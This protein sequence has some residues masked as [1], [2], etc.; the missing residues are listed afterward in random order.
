M[1]L[2]TWEDAQR[3]GCPD[4]SSHVQCNVFIAQGR[5]QG[6]GSSLL[7]TEGKD[8]HLVRF[9]NMRNE[10]FDVFFDLHRFTQETIPEVVK[11]MMARGG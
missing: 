11:S 2:A 4:L 9:T 1:K 10:R 3:L 5:D 7:L 6:V 8:S